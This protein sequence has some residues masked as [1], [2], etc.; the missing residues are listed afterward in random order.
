MCVEFDPLDAN[1]YICAGFSVGC[2]CLGFEEVGLNI[3]I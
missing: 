3:N 1:F 2:V